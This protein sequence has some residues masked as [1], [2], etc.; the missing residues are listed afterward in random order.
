M[1]NFGHFMYYIFH[2][3][4]HLSKS[5]VLSIKSISHYL[6]VSLLSS[7]VRVRSF[8]WLF[9]ESLDVSRNNAQNRLR[10]LHFGT[11]SCSVFCFITFDT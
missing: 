6:T 10:A 1:Y 9:S 2:Y 11:P 4:F 7:C 3:V 8:M 5:V